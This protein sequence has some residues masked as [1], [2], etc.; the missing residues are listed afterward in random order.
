MISK[1]AKANFTTIQKAVKAGDVA[2]LECTDKHTGELINV[3]CAVNFQGGE[4][5][6]V[7]LAKL[8]TGNPYDEVLPPQ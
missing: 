3:L 5:H 8:F 7:P 4:Y 6:M 2:L 1:G